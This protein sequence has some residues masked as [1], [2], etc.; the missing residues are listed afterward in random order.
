MDVKGLSGPPRDNSPAIGRVDTTTVHPTLA[1]SATKPVGQQ[2]FS[3]VWQV[4][5]ILQLMVSQVQGKT[6]N[7]A[8]P[9][10][11]SDAPIIQ[12]KT[13]LPLVP[14]QQVLVKVTGDI[15]KPGMQLIPSNQSPQDLVSQTLRQQ[16]PQQQAQAPLLANLNWAAKQ[17]PAQQATVPTLSPLVQQIVKTLVESLP[18]SQQLRDPNLLFKSMH[19]SG[20]YLEHT[21]QNRVTGQPH[22]N[23]EQDLRA[24]LL[25][26]AY[27]LRQ[28]TN[29]PASAAATATTPLAAA[30]A[31]VKTTAPE[32]A[33]QLMREA[34]HINNKQA[35]PSSNSA[36]AS[37]TQTPQ[38]QAASNASLAMM[39]NPKMMAEELLQQVEGVLSRIQSQ[40]L[41]SLQADQQGRQ[42]WMMELPVKN[43]EN[44]DLFDLRVQRDGK[45]KEQDDQEQSWSM[46]LAFD[47]EGLG[48]IRVQVGLVGEA[49]TANFW[50][51]L[52]DTRRLFHEH[53]EHLRSR[54]KQSGLDVSEL[55][56]QCGV[57][58]EPAE[59]L[60]SRLLDERV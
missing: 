8:L 47:L 32:V 49:I 58:P 53:I 52:P 28:Q 44:L 55:S 15:H 42:M 12:T 17:L 50:A 2:A 46:T 26:L 59:Y 56:C 19:L 5:Q 3:R 41:Q 38:P 30:A 43:E 34:A 33:A 40:Q 16:L 4:G 7:L 37:R 51:E 35:F 48:P 1:V 20:Q 31:T 45:E 11:I 57:P 39:N 9:P 36:P 14:G 18:T 22:F 60:E 23:P 27:A 29:L 24:Q 13:D 10:G 21:L 25:R 6:V 54:L